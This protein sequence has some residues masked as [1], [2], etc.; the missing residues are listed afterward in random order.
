MIHHKREENYSQC[1]ISSLHCFFLYRTN[2]KL[3]PH[4]LMI[5][6]S[7]FIINYTIFITYPLQSRY[8]VILQY[9]DSNWKEGSALLWRDNF[10]RFWTSHCWLD[11]YIESKNWIWWYF[12]NSIFLI[13]E[14][15]SWSSFCDKWNVFYLNILHLQVL[16]VLSLY[17]V[18]LLSWKCSL[19]SLYRK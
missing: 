4:M 16:L 14:W 3:L 2:H 10:I 1:P 8:C 17:R 5:S 15:N 13:K 12:D 9:H 6:S 18:S 11:Y 7:L 19:S